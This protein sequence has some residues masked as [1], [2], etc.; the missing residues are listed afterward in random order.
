MRKIF[1]TGTDTNCGKTYTTC[2]L[3][4]YFNSKKIFSHAIKPVATGCIQ[5][6]N[7]LI[8]E[9]EVLLNLNQQNFGEI[10]KYKYKLPVSPHIAAFRENSFIDP[11]EVLNFCNSFQDDF[12]ILL[13]EGAGG[14]L[15]PI[16]DQQTWMDFLIL[17]KIPVILVVGMKLG[18][19]NHSLLTDLALQSNK[20]E[21]IGWVANCL[22]PKMLE[23]EANILTLE[24]KLSA[25][26]L[27]KIN[28]SGEFI[29][30]ALVLQR[31]TF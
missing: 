13:I 7:T 27:G 24:Q 17:S 6:N 25:P 20:I 16:N 10:T 23:L 5:Q 3:V 26:L 29:P 31:G 14:L 21:T 4:N 28:Y 11:N 9:D 12:E 2:K 19:I 15:V 22:D 18:C 8:N 30:T 1:I